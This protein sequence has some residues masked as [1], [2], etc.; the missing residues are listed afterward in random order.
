[1][2]PPKLYVAFC[3]PRYEDY[4]FEVTGGHPAFKTQCGECEPKKVAILQQ[5]DLS[6]HMVYSGIS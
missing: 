6:G 3:R 2:G 4:I 5:I 1:M